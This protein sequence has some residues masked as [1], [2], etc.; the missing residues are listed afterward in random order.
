MIAHDYRRLM[1]RGLNRRRRRREIVARIET[2]LLG[3]AV[4]A[5]FLMVCAIADSI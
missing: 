1:E 5:V 2:A 3:F 4:G